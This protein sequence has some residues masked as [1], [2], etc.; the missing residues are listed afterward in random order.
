MLDKLITYIV[1]WYKTWYQV[2]PDAWTNR[3][4]T[5]RCCDSEWYWFTQHARTVTKYEYILVVSFIGKGKNTDLKQIT[6]KLCPIMLYRVHLAWAWL[7]LTTL[8]VID[9]DYISSCIHT[10]R[11]VLTYNRQIV[12]TQSISLTYKYQTLYRHVNKS[13]GFKLI[14]CAQT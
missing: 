13:G 14:S 1:W 12:Q 5:R 11:T 8:V 7:E 9:T 10:V 6:D 2:L 4:T 3:I